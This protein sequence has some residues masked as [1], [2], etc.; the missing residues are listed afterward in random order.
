MKLKILISCAALAVTVSGCAT[1]AL[2]EEQKNAAIA[3]CFK[4]FQ[5]YPAAREACIN[6]ARTADKKPTEANAS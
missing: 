4:D 2:T 3:K 6:R 1:S 5:N